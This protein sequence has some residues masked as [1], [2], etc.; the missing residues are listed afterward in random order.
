MANTKIDYGPKKI[1]IYVNN[2]EPYKLV[3]T[4][5]KRRRDVDGFGVDPFTGFLKKSIGTRKIIDTILKQLVQEVGGFD[6]VLSKAIRER[7]IR[8]LDDVEYVTITDSNFFFTI[9]F[10]EKNHF[11]F[12]ARIINF[13]KYEKAF[14]QIFKILKVLA[15]ESLLYRISGSLGAKDKDLEISFQMVYCLFLHKIHFL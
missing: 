2:Y 1:E 15:E 9:F 12:M 11:D 14:A 6:K 8:S 7:T 4:V 5:N 13:D 10:T 3:E